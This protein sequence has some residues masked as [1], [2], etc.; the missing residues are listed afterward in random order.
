M[1]REN[2]IGHAVPWRGNLKVLSTSD[3]VMAQF[4]SKHTLNDQR[5]ADEDMVLANLRT[6]LS[7]M[8]GE[9][10]FDYLIDIT[11]CRYLGQKK[12]SK[13]AILVSLIL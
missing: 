10:V 2:K 7:M 13:T 11:Q 3:E 8:E 4:K 9:Y 1:L 12:M 6:A 5:R